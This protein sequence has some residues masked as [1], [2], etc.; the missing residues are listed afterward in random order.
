MSS[1]APRTLRALSLCLCVLSGSSIHAQ[2]APGA[3][4]AHTESSAT[5]APTAS[6]ATSAPTASSA[7]S[8]A[9]SGSTSLPG[10]PARGKTLYQACTACHSIDDDDI[11][12]RHR[13]VFGRK[14]G[15]VPGYAYSS[16]LKASGIV[17]DQANLDR[18]L[19]NPSA[20][21]P[22]TK[23]FYLIDDAQKRADIIAYLA[24]LKYPG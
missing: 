4:S 13:G 20:M 12:P 6:S 10:D 15:S 18:W 1:P 19:T 21:V 9:P 2:T 16:A 17:W 8:S 7:T 5:S 24:E 23:M 3:T 11:G 22:G 14:A